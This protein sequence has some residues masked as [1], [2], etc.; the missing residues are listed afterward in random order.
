MSIVASK[1]KHDDGNHKEED[2]ANKLGPEFRDDKSNSPSEGGGENMHCTESDVGGDKG[3][4]S[5]EFVVGDHGE[6]ES[7]ISDLS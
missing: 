1:D 4:A 3:S 5:T 6:D 2:G 7:L